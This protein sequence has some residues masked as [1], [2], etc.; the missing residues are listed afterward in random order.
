[1]GEVD[2]DSVVVY[3]DQ[4]WE[5][6]M[7][8]RDLVTRDTV[9]TTQKHREVWRRIGGGWRLSRV[10]ELGGTILVNGKPYVE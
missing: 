6:L 7:L 10:K 1:M 8:Q 9:I 4:R 5:R 2:G 3:T